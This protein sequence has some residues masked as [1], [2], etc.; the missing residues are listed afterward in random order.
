[1]RLGMLQLPLSL[2]EAGLTIAKACAGFSFSLYVLHF[3]LLL[4]I[5]AK[6][7]P[8]LRWQPDL[9]HLLYG[10]SICAGVLLYAYAIARMT[11][12]NTAAVRAW[13]RR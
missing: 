4:L 10:A 11:E 9:R 3:P 12:G 6:F 2:P 7:L 8:T 5:R 13:I 1:M